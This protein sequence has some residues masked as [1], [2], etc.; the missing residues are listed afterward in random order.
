MPL[1]QSDSI[2]LE[3]YYFGDDAESIRLP[4]DGVR[5]DAGAIIVLGIPPDQLQALRWT[6]DF[7]SFDAQ[8]MRHRYPVS[9]PALVGPSQ[10]R[11]A[12]L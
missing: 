10:A 5:V 8:G 2:L 4:C 7:L 3:A 12:L 6:P 9:R 1:Y 11:F